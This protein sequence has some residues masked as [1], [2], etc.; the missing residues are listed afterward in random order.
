M[1]TSMAIT[2]NLS[3]ANKTDAFVVG[4]YPVGD[5]FVREFGDPENPG[6]N[7]DGELRDDMQQMLLVFY[8]SLTKD[9]VAWKEKVA[10]MMEQ[11]S[12]GIDLNK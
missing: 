10:D 3:N 4:T 1:L 11:F 6:L 5:T 9:D 12:N 7:E 2:P 8:H